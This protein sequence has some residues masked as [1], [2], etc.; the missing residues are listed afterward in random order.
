MT[1]HLIYTPD[2]KKKGVVTARCG[3]SV[4]RTDATAW[5]SDSVE[6]DGFTPVPEACIKCWPYMWVPAKD[7]IGR[8]QVP[9]AQRRGLRKI[10][11]PA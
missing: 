8:K 10:R 3:A 5:Y 2:A 7:G 4:P 1:L 6:E 11:R 9:R